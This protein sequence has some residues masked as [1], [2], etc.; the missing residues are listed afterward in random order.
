M[1][2]RSTWVSL[3][4]CLATPALTDERPVMDRM[5]VLDASGSM[6]GKTDGESKIEAARR[7]IADLMQDMSDQGSLGLTVYGHRKKGDCGDIETLVPPTQGAAAKPMI[8]EAVQSLVP[9]GKTP[10]SAAV[11]DAAKALRFSENKATVILIS[12]GRET[13]DADPC[14]IAAQLE[15]EGI[16][17]TTHVVGF[18]IS[19]DEAAEQLQCIAENTGGRFV[20]ASN[21]SELAEALEDVTAAVPVPAQPVNS[22]FEDDFDSA[23]LAEIWQV[24]N[25][26][27]DLLRQQEGELIAI[28]TGHRSEPWNSEALNRVV[29]SQPV[30]QGDFDLT[31][32]FRILPQTGRD[33]VVIGLI[34]EPNTLLSASLFFEMT[35]CGIQPLLYVTSQIAHDP[36]RPELNEVFTKVFDEIGM[37]E[38]CQPGATKP[39]EHVQSFTERPASLT[40]RKRGRDYT[41]VLRFTPSEDGEHVVESQPITMLRA[42]ENA[43]FSVAQR[44]VARGESILFADRFSVTQPGQ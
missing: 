44:P 7:V 3:A 22:Y 23:E 12:D 1:F 41:A 17:F 9:K 30:P 35:G 14:A 40:L 38:F 19:D 43:F 24:L 33:E 42:P 13:C 37:T 39:D 6:W 11:R 31:L 18:D 21:A 15:D 16:D 2:F 26:A 4:F 27:P 34:T 29:L 5:I 28:A 36:V 10:L 32:D 25:P 8:V 20:S